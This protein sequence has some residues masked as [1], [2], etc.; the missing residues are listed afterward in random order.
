MRS[1][2]IV[3]DNEKA[4]ESLRK[5]AV[6]LNAIVYTADN[7]ADA[8]RIACQHNID[9]FLVDII[10]NPQIQGDVSGS[11]FVLDIKEMPRYARAIVIFIT[12][13]DRKSVV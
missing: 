1:V 11:K 10:L 13:R 2:L 8:Y 9:I 5:I 7:S 6:S 12:S 4:M 3:E